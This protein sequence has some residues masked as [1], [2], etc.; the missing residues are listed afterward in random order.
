MMQASPQENNFDRNISS[1]LQGYQTAPQVNRFGLKGP[2]TPESST[3]M[4]VS[5]RSNQPSE[6]NNPMLTSKKV[7]AKAI[8]EMGSEKKKQSV[9]TRRASAIEEG[10]GPEGPPITFKALKEVQFIESF[11]DTDRNSKFGRKPSTVTP[12]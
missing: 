5:A 4:N 7:F 2:F 1:L 11:Q 12:T 9:F 3:F 6:R 10:R 8:A